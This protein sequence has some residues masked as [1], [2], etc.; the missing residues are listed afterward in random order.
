MENEFSQ[1]S[2]KNKSKPHGFISIKN[3]QFKLL[4][5]LSL[6]IFSFTV[7][8]YLSDPFIFNPF[9]GQLNPIILVFLIL[10]LG[11][12]L[13]S[14]LDSQDFCIYTHDNLK[15]LLLSVI[16]APLLALNVILIDLNFNY[17]EDINVLL[18]H[19][20]LY[21]PTMGFIVEILFHI[22]PLSLIL[23]FLTNRN[24]KKILE[25][26]IWFTILVIPII[27]PLFQIIFGTSVVFPLW[28][29]IL[30]GIHLYFFN[31]FQLVIFKKYGFLSMF[32][33]RMGYYMIWHILWGYLRLIIIY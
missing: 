18:P 9:F 16:V 27:E 11:F 1:K 10:I 26:K 24:K 21:Y 12:F 17:S 6:L 14:Y 20:L 22:A 23:Y 33:F 3:T 13:L 31:L 5:S 2:L 15:V 32:L 8:L 30:F 7:V 4:I 29:I 25:K 28:I 19:S